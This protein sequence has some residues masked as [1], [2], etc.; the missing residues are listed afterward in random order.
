M[1]MKVIGLLAAGIACGIAFN[2]VA[3]DGMT[4]TSSETSPESPQLAARLELNAY[5]DLCMAV[6]SQVQTALNQHQNDLC[7]LPY[8]DASIG[9]RRPKW[10]RV[11]PRAHIDLLRRQLPTTGAAYDLMQTIREREMPNASPE[12]VQNKF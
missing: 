1:M 3:A 12:E 4:S 8:E 7:P 10:Q 9:L 11:D 2:D 6:L 5:A